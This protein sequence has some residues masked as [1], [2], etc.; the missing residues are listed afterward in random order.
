MCDA[1]CPPPT[2][3]LRRTSEGPGDGDVFKTLTCSMCRVARCCEGEGKAM[4]ECALESG[5]DFLSVLNATHQSDFLTGE[6][7]NEGTSN[8]TVSDAEAPN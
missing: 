1:E 2:N 5:V 3:R 7:I 8:L 6:F 4:E